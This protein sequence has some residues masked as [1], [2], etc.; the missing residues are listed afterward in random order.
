[1]FSKIL[2]RARKLLLTCTLTLMS[3]AASVSA[4]QT[5][6]LKPMTF[7]L[8]G[9]GGNCLGC[10]WIAASGYIT[11]DS[12]KNYLALNT[13]IPVLL[14]S[15]GGDLEGAV[16]LADAFRKRGAWIGIGQN[17]P[18]PDS[19]FFDQG[20]GEC[21]GNCVWAFAGG[22]RRHADEGQIELP[23]LSKDGALTKALFEHVLDMG[24]NPD[25]LNR[26]MEANPTDRMVNNA[27][28]LDAY[29]LDYNPEELQPWILQ[30]SD[31]ALLAS[32]SSRDGMRQIQYK[33]A[34]KGKRQ[35]ILREEQQ[36]ISP[37]AMPLA[38]DMISEMEVL[39]FAGKTIP[40]K[41]AKA[42]DEDFMTE[43]VLNL[44]SNFRASFAE[45]DLQL[46]NEEAPRYMRFRLLLN[47]HEMEQSFAMIDQHCGVN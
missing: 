14:H 12:A 28:A 13:S 24:L 19:P 15:H 23:D 42:L 2:S 29:G 46:V 37:Y 33:C 38:L 9:N 4:Q 34:S 30:T 31:G 3:F 41:I 1:M 17:A 20:A 6:D 27:E 21:K 32:S 45:D 22:V 26:A 10:E 43:I 39:D 11:A 35:L 36:G 7:S 44:P 8:S 40:V 18:L 5:A 25:I 16:K 47:P